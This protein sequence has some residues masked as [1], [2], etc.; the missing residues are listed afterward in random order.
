MITQGCKKC[1]TRG[2]VE[3]A[4]KYRLIRILKSTNILK[5][6]AWSAKLRKKPIKNMGNII[7]DVSLVANQ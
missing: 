6:L 1:S 5:F 2:V 4:I 3:L 7:Y